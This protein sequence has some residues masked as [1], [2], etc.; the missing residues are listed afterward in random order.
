MIYRRIR[1]AISTFLSLARR[2]NPD[3]PDEKSGQV[4]SCYFFTT[5]IMVFKKASILKSTDS[6][7]RLSK[8]YIALLC[9]C[10]ILPGI[11]VLAQ[12]K[13]TSDKVTVNIIHM[14]RLVFNKTD[15]G[16]YNRLIG[17]VILQ[18]GTDTLYC[19]SAYQNTTSK[20]FEAFS[21]VKIAQ[22]DGTQGKSDYLK[23]TSDKKLA[24]MRGN[25]SLTDGKNNLK[26]EDLTYDLAAKVGN[27][28]NGGTLHNDSTTVT[29]N[30]GV[31]NGHSK[32]ARF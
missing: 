10:F 23:Y 19:D 27:Y 4:G 11:D 12:K 22:Q 29:S 6:L 30:A 17:D 15:T 13:D 16:E 2:N 31:Y 28:Y 25:V 26:S 3:S 8:V 14:E 9:L 7:A 18:Q 24:Y 20:N 32:D 5:L 1:A 21:N